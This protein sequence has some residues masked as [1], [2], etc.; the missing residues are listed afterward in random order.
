[1][2]KVLL[3]FCLIVMITGWYSC[4][5]DTAPIPPPIVTGHCDSTRVNFTKDLLPIINLNCQG[6]ACH[7]AGSGQNNFTSLGVSQGDID[8]I[9][10]RIRAAGTSACGARMPSGAPP[11]PAAQTALF[12]KWKTDNF[13]D[14]Q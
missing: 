1:M 13:Y 4:T 11:L 7:S 8:N 3:S 9:L 2:K 5:K 12:A 6:S 14:C 10:C